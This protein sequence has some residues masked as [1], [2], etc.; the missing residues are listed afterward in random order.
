MRKWALKIQEFTPGNKYQAVIRHLG[1]QFGVGWALVLDMSQKE[2]DVYLYF[3]LLLT[4]VLQEPTSNM[5]FCL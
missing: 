4:G 1:H 2:C 5:F 3:L